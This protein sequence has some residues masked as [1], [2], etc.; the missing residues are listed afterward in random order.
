MV[1]THPA[2]FTRVA[3]LVW[4]FAALGAAAPHD[5]FVVCGSQPNQPTVYFSGVLQ[6]P[7]TAIQGFQNGFT[8]F[9]G[10]NYSY[11]GPVGCLQAN[12]AANAQNVLNTRSAALRN[13]KKNVVDTGWAEPAALAAAPIAAPPA[14]SA[15]Q[16]AATAAGTGSGARSGGSASSKAGPSGGT[17]SAGSAGSN[18]SGGG[19]V[20][21]EL[22]S[23]LGSVLGTGGGSDGG[24][25]GGGGAKTKG[26]AATSGGSGDQ[27]GAG[28]VASTLAAAFS[29]RSSVSDTSPQ[30]TPHVQSAEGLGSAEAQNTKLV[31]YGC[32]RQG[33]QVACV[34]E[35]TNQNSKDT[36]VQSAAVWKDTFIVDDRGDRHQRSNGFF[37]NVDGDQRSQLDI[38][39][40]K[41]AHF[42][43]MFDG[44]PA[45]V[46]KVTLRSTSADLDV[47][48]VNLVAPATDAQKH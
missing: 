12:T 11:K 24:S 28:Q 5:V 19:G 17:G 47:E 9:L 35:L 6:G 36:L 33:G 10:Q 37:L 48:D 43:L 45:K 21:S 8:A 23:I 31:V 22:A 25:S 32:G 4:P 26:S 7:A 18:G 3:V 39:Y 38:S 40:G 14:V 15:K 46:Q 30:S 16:P 20:S 29:S 13:Q 42:I 34:T 27:G 41:S 44:V 1:H 2:L